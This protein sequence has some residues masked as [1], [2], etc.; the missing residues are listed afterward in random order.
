MKKKNARKQL[1]PHLR[2]TGHMFPCVLYFFIHT[3]PNNVGP[4]RQQPRDWG[5]L[6][7]SLSLDGGGGAQL[8]LISFARLHGI[9][10]GSIDG[11]EAGGTHSS[12]TALGLGIS[13]PPPPN[14]F[15]ISEFFLFGTG[16]G[17]NSVL[18]TATRLQEI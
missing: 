1:S 17:H 2:K 7:I 14:T 18:S 5:S 11:M 3:Q 13:A 10:I 6:L 4:A 12:P 16:R 15:Q 8:L 9:C